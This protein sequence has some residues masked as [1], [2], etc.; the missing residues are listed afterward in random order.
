MMLSTVT[1]DLES[2][3]RLALGSDS[4]ALSNLPRDVYAELQHREAPLTP[5]RPA[6]AA[7][8]VES[9][10]PEPQGCFEG[11][12]ASSP[13]LKCE[14]S[15][16]E[17]GEMHAEVNCKEELGSV[18]TG[19]GNGE[20]GV[21]TDRRAEPPLSPMQGDGVGPAQANE[22]T[23]TECSAAEKARPIDLEADITDMDVDAGGAE[24]LEASAAG[25]CGRELTE[26][27]S[28]CSPIKKSEVPEAKN[29]AGLV[30]ADSNDAVSA[31]AWALEVVSMETEQVETKTQNSPC[32]GDGNEEPNTNNNSADNHP[33]GG[34]AHEAGEPLPCGN[35]LEKKLSQAE[36]KD[37]SVAKVESSGQNVEAAQSTGVGQDLMDN[38][39]V[40]P[41]FDE[42]A[43]YIRPHDE[44]EILGVCAENEVVL[45]V[46][47][48]RSEQKDAE[49]SVRGEGEERLP[50]ELSPE[51]QSEV[52]SEAEPAAGLPGE[53]RG[54]P[55]LTRSEVDQAERAVPCECVTQTREGGS[56]KGS[57]P[58]SAGLGS[59]AHV[60]CGSDRSY[61]SQ[62]N[63]NI[64]V[65]ADCKIA[66]SVPAK[67]LNKSGCCPLGDNVPA[68]APSKT[69]RGQSVTPQACDA[70]E[71]E[72][73]GAAQPPESDFSVRLSG[74]EDPVELLQDE[75][76]LSRQAAHGEA[77]TEKQCDARLENNEA[78][79]VAK[80][81]SE[82]ALHPEDKPEQR[83]SSEAA[84]DVG[85]MASADRTGS[86]GALGERDP[87]R[88]T[89]SGGDGVKL[90]VSECRTDR[91]SQLNSVDEKDTLGTPESSI[92]NPSA[93]ENKSATD[94]TPHGAGAAA[95][96][97]GAAV[98]GLCGTLEQETPSSLIDVEKPL[99]ESESGQVSGSVEIPP[100][101]RE[102]CKTAAV[103]DGTT[104]SV[105]RAVELESGGRSTSNDKDKSVKETEGIETSW[106]PSE[107]CRLPCEGELFCSETSQSQG[108][109]KA[110]PNCHAEE[111]EIHEDPVDPATPLQTGCDVSG[112]EERSSAESSEP[113]ENRLDPPGHFR[114]GCD[115]EATPEKQPW[116]GAEE[117]AERPR[118]SDEELDCTEGRSDSQGKNL[119]SKDKV[120]ASAEGG[121]AL[122][123]SLVIKQQPA[124]PKT[125]SSE[126]D[127]R[128]EEIAE[129]PLERMEHQP[130][131]CNKSTSP[132]HAASSVAC[133]QSNQALLE[134]ELYDKLVEE[135][136]LSEREGTTECTLQDPSAPH[137]SECCNQKHSSPTEIDDS[138]KTSSCDPPCTSHTHSVPVEPGKAPAGKRAVVEGEFGKPPRKKRVVELRKQPGRGCKAGTKVPEPFQDLRRMRDSNAQV[139]IRTQ[140]ANIAELDHGTSEAMNHAVHSGAVLNA[141]LPKEERV[142][143]SLRNGTSKP[144]KPRLNMLRSVKCQKNIQE[145]LLLKLSNVASSLVP[146]RSPQKL[147]PFYRSSKALPYR[148]ESGL[149]ARA[150]DIS[151]CMKTKLKP[152]WY[153]SFCS[154]LP[155]LKGHTLK[156]V[157]FQSLALSCNA[158]LS[159]ISLYRMDRWKPLVT[160]TT[161]VFPVSFHVRLGSMSSLPSG[162]D[163]DDEKSC[164]SNLMLHEASIQPPSSS[165]SSLSSEWTCSSFSPDVS[166]G[167]RSVVQNT[168]LTGFSGELHPVVF[169]CSGSSEPRCRRCSFSECQE[170]VCRTASSS[171]SPFSR[172]GLHTVLALS[173]PACYR[174]WTRRRCLGSRVPAVQERFLSQFEEGLKVSSSTLKE[175]LFPSLHYSLGR[176]VAA[177]SSR[178]P[179]ACLPDFTTFSCLDTDHSYARQL[180]Q[181]FV[182]SS[183]AEDCAD[184]G[185]A[186]ESDLNQP[187]CTLQREPCLVPLS[188]VSDRPV[189][190]QTAAQIRPKSL[191][192]WSSLPAAS[193]ME[194]RASDSAQRSAALPEIL[195]VSY[196]EMKEQSVLEKSLVSEPGQRTKR[197]SQIRIRKTVPKPD[198]NLTPMGL[199]K[200]KRLKKK[201][202]SL[203]EIYTNKNYKSPP[204]NRSLETIFE[205]PKEKNGA[206][207]CI[208]QQKR[209]RVLEFQDFTVPR[210]RRAR[211]GVK[212]KSSRTRGRKAA[213]QGCG[214]LDV[215]LIEKL[216]ALEHFFKTEHITI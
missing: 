43:P 31:A 55:V 57:T 108:S 73:Q 156:N 159:K 54:V 171:S 189:L 95:V 110:I 179:A 167:Y 158:D 98:N 24:G 60:H 15:Q 208:G 74:E 48:S 97:D 49:D 192:A 88:G 183:F 160:F 193:C 36:L 45:G 154:R 199:P 118:A 89:E 93:L 104:E 162:D 184:A 134:R 21:R 16:D 210:K 56:A 37:V 153:N 137:T 213:K 116:E 19:E 121:A 126:L 211:T 30:T 84:A 138:S 201:E 9:S 80:Q 203:E 166:A 26:S 119:T 124:D 18:E 52:I 143:P 90:G 214:E 185:V 1:A 94:I 177:W 99:T 149:K 29:K 190:D 76:D 139:F 176:I 28:S 64:E 169:T 12:L 8:G 101:P 205:E 172:F 63:R 53:G 182:A 92:G 181:S 6:G 180:L 58:C 83:A 61:C 35:R 165:S 38:H 59:P 17:T 117:D 82:D 186:N 198:N 133:S 65:P 209:K 113:R 109:C 146:V 174:V 47:R 128:S 130:A 147:R 106:Q 144:H 25:T 161:P 195:G 11:A 115:D 39:W 206:L 175:N 148:L 75:T 111:S 27:E 107:D 62:C 215:L 4:P 13:A 103:S 85:A 136:I 68:R 112:D 41:R 202:F 123:N 42:L 127:G 100:Q 194:C 178:G 22:I 114:T 7:G 72:S 50:A 2:S 40:H 122:K 191:M 77:L 105:C 197:V 168:T 157:T 152:Y 86:T 87:D 46:D 125:V 5:D 155:H 79:S 212:L 33:C 142:F 145:P 3:Q 20:G 70:L 140:V 187:D 188:P 44:D 207:V 69:T 102:G 196:P 141:N 216:S 170:L 135:T 131:V 129:V 173:S 204:S 151:V 200:P 34:S 66:S 132:L 164:S 32:I 96:A 23:V 163:D 71:T 120:E 14:V 78:T 51:S 91:G 10:L 150:A 81:K 67:H